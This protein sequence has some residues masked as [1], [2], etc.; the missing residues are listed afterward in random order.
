MCSSFFQQLC[1]LHLVNG[2]KIKSKPQTNKPTKWPTWW[3]L[4][5]K[6][7]HL[8]SYWNDHLQI[9]ER[10][11]AFS[12]FAYLQKLGTPESNLCILSLNQKS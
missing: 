9:R 2:G 7:K 6:V 10:E 12:F 8:P 5:A 1:K 11:L 3:K 4:L